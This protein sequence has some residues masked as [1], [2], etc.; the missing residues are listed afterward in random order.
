MY[1]LLKRRRCM[2]IA[3]F[4]FTNSLLPACSVV[5][6]KVAPQIYNK[7][8]QPLTPNQSIEKQLT[9]TA[10]SI[11]KSLNILAAAQETQSAPLLFT[12]PLVTPEGG[13]GGTIDIDWTGPIAPLVHKLGEL[14]HYR[15]KL[16]GQEPAIPIIVSITAKN[17][18]IAEVLQN[19]G[20]QAGKKAQLLVFPD[21]KVIEIRYL[22]T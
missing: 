15:V 2:L 6:N 7:D 10:S 3:F 19:A 4:I 18:I 14:T 20:L 11:E 9:E 17:A 16:L 13:M 5:R 21:S 22:N 12:P 8:S 1:K